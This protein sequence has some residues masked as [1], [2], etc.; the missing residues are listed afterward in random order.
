MKN[1]SKQGIRAVLDRVGNW[2][3]RK[4][5][6][7]QKAHKD[8]RVKHEGSIITSKSCSKLWVLILGRFRVGSSP[9]GFYWDW[10]V[11][12]FSI[13]HPNHM[14]RLRLNHY[15]RNWKPLVMLMIWEI[16]NLLL[17]LTFLSSHHECST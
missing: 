1:E 17:I 3:R 16:L 14:D 5:K 7:R 15:P 11:K 9:Q 10:A 4:K 12:C 2:K 6:G 13:H 8:D